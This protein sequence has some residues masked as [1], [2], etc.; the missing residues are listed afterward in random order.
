VTSGLVIQEPLFERFALHFEERQKVEV[1]TDD[2]RVGGPA[3]E[4]GPLV[5][6]MV[7]ADGLITQDDV[8]LRQEDEVD[9]AE[10]L[11]RQLGED[12][13][14]LSR[15]AFSILKYGKIQVTF[16]ANPLVCRD[17]KS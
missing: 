11:G 3:V 4:I 17:P 1:L 12:I 8:V 10:P 14:L 15:Q 16:A 13:E 2:E 9:I 7:H 6:D 5:D